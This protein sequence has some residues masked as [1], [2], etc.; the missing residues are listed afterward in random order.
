MKLGDSWMAHIDTIRNES[1][2]YPNENECFFSDYVT[3]AIDA[4]RRVIFET[5]ETCYE[6]KYY[7]NLTFTP[8]NLVNKKMFYFFETEDTTIKKK[9]I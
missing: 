4:S 6:N 3:K 5:S 7:L 1:R 9:M 2:Y 8:T